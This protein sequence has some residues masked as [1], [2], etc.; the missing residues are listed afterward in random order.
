M[1]GRDARVKLRIPS[2]FDRVWLR[3]AGVASDAAWKLKNKPTR[4]NNV[5][6]TRAMKNVW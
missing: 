1:N 3:L 4:F 5:F 6:L 2:V